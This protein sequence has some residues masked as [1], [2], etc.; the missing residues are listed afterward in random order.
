M[1]CWRQIDD[2]VQEARRQRA[3]QLHASQRPSRKPDFLPIATLRE[4]LLLDTDL[5]V[6][7]W[8]RHYN[9]ILATTPPGEAAVLLTRDFGAGSQARTVNGPTVSRY[10]LDKAGGAPSCSF[11]F[12][13]VLQNN[14][15]WL[16]TLQRLLSRDC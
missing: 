10:I 16:L 4:L 15:T 2:A 8:L 14:S 11:C 5:D 12:A 6:L 7:R 3:A 1:H 13:S 9:P